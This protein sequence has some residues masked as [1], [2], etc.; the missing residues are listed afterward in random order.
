MT[1][2]IEVNDV[3]KTFGDVVALDG[4]SMAVEQGTT[5][6]LLG[7]NGAGKSTLF[8]LLIGHVSPD[9]GTLRVTGRDVEKTGCS[10]RQTVGYLPER[11][12]FPPHLTGRE[13]LRF[14]GRMRDI[15]SEDREARVDQVLEQVGLSDAADRPVRGYSKGMNR[16]LGLATSLLSRPQLLLLD[17]PTAGLDPLGIEAFHKVIRELHEDSTL[18]VMLSTHAL[19]EAETL[20]DRIGILHGGRL[21][22]NGS[23]SALKGVLGTGVTVQITLESG[24]DVDAIRGVVEEHAAIDAVSDRVLRTHCERHSVP[25]LLEALLEEDGVAG[26]EVTE[27]DLKHVFVDAVYDATEVST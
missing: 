4:L 14:H 19:S 11:V 2:S 3:R 13:V 17:E 7:T 1:R 5:Y 22:R 27:Q 16:R 12:G 6:G 15:P 8:R 24:F 25:G 18:T 23:V 10:V 20:C 26:F 21:L 9:S